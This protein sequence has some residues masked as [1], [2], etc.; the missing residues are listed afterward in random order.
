[1]ARNV[2]ISFRY[3]DGYMYKDELANLFDKN[4]D[5][6]DFSEDQ[7]RSGLSDDS[8]RKYLF[9]KLKRASVT[10]I[11]LT[12]MAINYFKNYGQYDDW[13]YDEVRY[14]LEDREGNATNGLVAVYVKEAEQHIIGEC[15]HLRSDSTGRKLIETFPGIKQFDNL[16]YKNMLNVKPEYKTERREK[17]FDSNLDSYCSLVAYDDFK[18]NIG[19]YVDLAFKKRNELYKY[20]IVKR[21]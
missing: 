3:K 20:N 7:D 13:I 16:A 6:I 10:I 11:L 12:P 2:F 9:G 5:T 18:N 17:L 21:L 15:Y 14:S 4:K 19:Y 8:I 1:M